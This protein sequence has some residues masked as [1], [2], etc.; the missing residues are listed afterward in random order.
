MFT[1]VTRFYKPSFLFRT[2]TKQFG[3]EVIPV[4]SFLAVR[5]NMAT[6]T[7]D[8]ASDRIFYALVAN[9]PSSFHSADLRRFFVTFIENDGFECFHYKHRPEGQDPNRGSG[10]VSQSS[11]TTEETLK[12]SKYSNRTKQGTEKGKDKRCCC[13]VKVREIKYQELVQLYHRKH[14]VNKSGKSMPQQCFVSKIKIEPSS[15]AHNES[16]IPIAIGKYYSRFIRFY[17]CV[18]NYCC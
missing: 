15:G 9:I 12:R 18:K 6:K 3:Y 4:A 14:W 10:D 11:D 2:W 1:V 16:H 7:N 13:I 8:M 5:A 17:V